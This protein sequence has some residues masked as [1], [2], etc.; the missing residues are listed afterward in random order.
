MSSKRVHRKKPVELV[1]SSS[2]RNINEQLQVDRQADKTKLAKFNHYGIRAVPQDIHRRQSLTAGYLNLKDIVELRKLLLDSVLTPLLD[3]W[4]KERAPEVTRK[5][6][7]LRR[8]LWR[9]ILGKATPPL[10]TSDLNS[11][12]I[13]LP[14]QSS[15]GIEVWIATWLVT[16]HMVIR[17]SPQCFPDEND[18]SI[19]KYLADHSCEDWHRAYT[20][21]KS[22]EK[23]YYWV[24]H[25]VKK[26]GGVAC[27]P[28][29]MPPRNFQAE[30]VL[31]TTDEELHLIENRE[32]ELR[33]QAKRAETFRRAQAN[34]KVLLNAPYSIE[35]CKTDKPLSVEIARSGE[36]SLKTTNKQPPRNS[37]I[38]ANPSSQQ[39][40]ENPTQHHP[41]N[42][43]ECLHILGSGLS[44]SS[45]TK[46][47]ASQTNPPATSYHYIVPPSLPAVVGVTYQPHLLHNMPPGTLHLHFVDSKTRASSCT[48]ASPTQA[49]ATMSQF[50]QRDSE[51]SMSY[52]NG[53]FDP[54][55]R[56]PPPIPTMESAYSPEERS[57]SDNL[58]PQLFAKPER[59]TPPPIPYSTKPT[60]H[61]RTRLSHT[62]AE[63]ELGK[64]SATETS[65]IKAD[66][67]NEP[68]N[69][70]LEKKERLVEM[71]FDS[72]EKVSEG[73]K[74][75]AHVA[76]TST[77]VSRRHKRIK[78]ESI[79]GVA[80]E[81]AIQT[82]STTCRSAFIQVSNN[83]H[84]P[85]KI[86]RT[87]SRP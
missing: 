71:R 9:Y 54:L 37:L 33:K 8:D 10:T 87:S 26:L 23:V 78:N 48:D 13:P 50:D 73:L 63:E 12:S 14:P 72:D 65:F 35:Q 3:A 81:D 4:Y 83:E 74:R 25:W 2:P 61:Q 17:N 85:V 24:D 57:V 11:H 18:P 43:P 20:V 44:E 58:Q 75:E 69:S 49:S 41:H 79:A 21:L 82:P 53:Y 39:S 30:E 36:M 84:R 29:D 51:E 56:I 5:N 40:I 27:S 62:S 22:Y 59:R 16:M 15:Q 66:P 76:I 67:A 77:S 46:L 28:L 45:L 64:Y 32:A 70:K 19:P 34:H 38:K 1:A 6:H 31:Y 47:H 42:Y 7:D 55:L 60:S 80:D 52:R 68:A 86:E